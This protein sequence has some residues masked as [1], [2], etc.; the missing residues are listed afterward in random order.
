MRIAF[1]GIRS[2]PGRYGGFETVA[3]QLAP[4]LVRRGVDLTVYCQRRYTEPP[5]PASFEGVKLVHLP[6]LERRALEETS[7]EAA[8]LAH[9]VT[10]HYDAIYVFGMR[11]TTLFAPLSLARKNVVFN[12]DGHDWQRRK[13]GPRARRYLLYSERLAARIAP[14]RLIADSQAIA[15][16]FREQYGVSPT[17]IPY[18]APVVDPPDPAVLNR[19]DLEAK[20]YYLVLCRLEPENN[21]DVIIRAFDAVGPKRDLVIVGGAKYGNEYIEQLRSMASDRVR[22]LGPVYDPIAVDALYHHSFAYIHGHEVGG[23]NPALLHAMGA[24]AC[25]L[26]NGVVYNREV[27][28]D[29]GRYWT[30][31]DGDLGDVMSA[32]DDDPEQALALGEA[33]RARAKAAYDWERIADQYVD[34]FEQLVAT[35]RSERDRR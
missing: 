31:A 33:A 35:K 23:T 15:A 9:A 26:A 8:S 14:G 1:I 3:T 12:T 25:V 4:R 6:S 17:F 22:F 16:Y 18:G 29:A 28:A 21:V 32:L 27:L 2:I 19:F 20:G 13:W 34:Y 10:R 11:A 7:H 24:G 30:P 5:R